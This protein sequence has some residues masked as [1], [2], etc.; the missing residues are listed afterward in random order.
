MFPV[1]GE[2]GSAVAAICHQVSFLAGPH[3]TPLFSTP[4]QAPLLLLL[5]FFLP[6]KKKKKKS[7]RDV[8]FIG[9]TVADSFALMKRTN[10]VHTFSLVI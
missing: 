6:F 9:P 2:P 3:S 1:D 8:L 5:F 10:R 4:H 7:P